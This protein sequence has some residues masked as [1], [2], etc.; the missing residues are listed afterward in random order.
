[1]DS[2]V[3]AYF[4]L[5]NVDQHDNNTYELYLKAKYFCDFAF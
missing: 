5:T 2:K 3:A 1:M 4:V